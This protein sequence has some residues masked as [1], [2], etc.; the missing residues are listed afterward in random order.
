MGLLCGEEVR[1]PANGVGDWGFES[2]S[3]QV[4]HD[5]YRIARCLFFTFS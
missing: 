5:M 3:W 1:A 4:Y 2:V